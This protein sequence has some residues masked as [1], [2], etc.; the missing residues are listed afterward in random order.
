MVEGGFVLRFHDT[1]ESVL[2]R[3]RLESAWDINSCNNASVGADSRGSGSR[4]EHG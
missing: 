1:C 2:F 3:L 4:G